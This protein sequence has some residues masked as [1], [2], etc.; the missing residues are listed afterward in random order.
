MLFFTLANVASAGY[1]GFSALAAAE[2]GSWGVA[3]VMLSIALACA[4]AGG[5]CGC[6]CVFQLSEGKSDDRREPE[7][8]SRRRP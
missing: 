6:A 3:C 4:V 5:A 2:R 1:L 8:V 7:A